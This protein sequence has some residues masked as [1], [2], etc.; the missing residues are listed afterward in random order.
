MRKNK[1]GPKY[2]RIVLWPRKGE[3]KKPFVHPIRR[4]KRA[5]P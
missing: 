2:P 1:Y 3:K 4:G 5:K